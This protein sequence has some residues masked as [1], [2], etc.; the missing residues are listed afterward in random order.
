[1][2]N[3]RVVCRQLGFP[4]A[5]N[6]LRNAWFGRG[7]GQIWLDDV[8]CSGSESSIVNCQHRGWGVE[9]CDH[10][11]DASVICSSK[12][13]TK[14]SSRRETLGG[15]GGGY[16]IENWQISKLIGTTISGGETS[17]L[18]GLGCSYQFH[19]VSNCVIIYHFIKILTCISRR[20][21]MNGTTIL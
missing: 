6:A 3:G 17:L 1:M 15:G 18:D 10:S 8:R 11:D 4:D 13:C 19:H 2:N 5:V 14:Q 9:N 20:A 21:Q 7:S 12:L 16:P